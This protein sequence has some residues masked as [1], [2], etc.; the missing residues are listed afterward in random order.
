MIGVKYGM[1]SHNQESGGEKFR[2]ELA[3]LGQKWLGI[4]AEDY[5]CLMGTN[6]I[7]FE[8]INTAPVIGIHQGSPSETTQ[9]LMKSA[10]CK[11]K[12]CLRGRIT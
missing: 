10:I 2:K 7:P 5:G 9:K 8:C 12:N 3:S 6:V 11:G 4:S 1:D